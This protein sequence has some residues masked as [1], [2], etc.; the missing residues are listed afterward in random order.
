MKVAFPTILCLPPSVR[1]PHADPRQQLIK[2]LTAVAP[3]LS[4]LS[5]LDTQRCGKGHLIWGFNRVRGGV[6]TSGV[7]R[8]QHL[9]GIPNLAH[10]CR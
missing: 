6:T 9:T 2:V 10:D 3:L 4:V 5:Q 1:L 8:K 7:R